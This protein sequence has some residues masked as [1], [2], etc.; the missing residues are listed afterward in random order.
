MPTKTCC[1]DPRLERLVEYRFFGGMTMKDAAEA[2][3]I[4]LRTAERHWM[5]A[6]AHLLQALDPG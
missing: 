2:M 5:R 6:K 1:L 3:G 4:S